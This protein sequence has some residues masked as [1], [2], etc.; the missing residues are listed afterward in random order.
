MSNRLRERSELHA[1][2]Q[3]ELA[4]WG[5]IECTV[6]RVGEVYQDQIKR[7]GHHDRL[8]DL[9]LVKSLNITTL[10]YPVLWERVAPE[11][12]DQLDWSWTDERL[13]RLQ[14]LAIQPIAGLVHHGCGPRY[15]TYDR[16]A[17]EQGLARYA[18]QVAERYP[19]IES[20]TPINEPLTTARFSGLYGHWYP[21][22][23][24]N[25]V[26]VDILLREC[27]ATCRAMAEIRKVRPD[28][29]LVQTDD[30][31]KTHSTP[32]LSYQADLEN[33]R[34]WLSWDLLC[35]RVTPD[36]P[37]WG[38]LRQSGASERE[39][40]S[41]ADNP[42]APSVI[43][44]N[45]YVTSERYLDE[46]LDNYPAHLHGG[47]GH[48]RYV[49]TEMV[50]AMPEHRTGLGGLLLEAWDRY[51]IPLVITE[52]HLGDAADE[53][54]RWLGEVW[55]QAQ[56][57]KEMGADVRAV[58]VWALFG[59]YDWHCLLTREEN[60]HEPGVFNVRSGV[61]KPTGL[62]TMVQRLAAGEP[63]DALIPPGRGWWQ[64]NSLLQ[65]Y[66]DLAV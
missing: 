8:T 66:A 14:Q 6:N 64:A 24:S 62:T 16:P 43:G 48:Q 32:L 55:Q 65:L 20:Y 47:N 33:E 49:D 38:F 9:D 57:A 2:Q 30:L 3:Q 15:A 37:L 45:H 1:L 18:R 51:G 54:K 19:W 44:V 13:G 61:P 46:N 58:T 41:L 28:A 31:G 26:F 34:R 12:P 23:T 21:H 35:G 5:G 42:C 36:H 11:H 53:Q 50:R 29:K 4:L 63:V 60:C 59:L 25:R 40:W 17:F 27:R 52:A 10:R 22:A 7:S 39:L 56:L